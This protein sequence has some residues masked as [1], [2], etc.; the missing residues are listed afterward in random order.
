MSLVV[1]GPCPTSR[2][3]HTLE[4]T[5]SSLGT[6][7]TRWCSTFRIITHRPAIGSPGRLWG[8]AWRVH[9][10]RV[11]LRETNE[12]STQMVACVRKRPPDFPQTLAQRCRERRRT[13]R[14]R[15]HAG[16]QQKIHAGSRPNSSRRT[17]NVR[18]SA[19]PLRSS[20][21]TDSKCYLERRASS[22]SFGGIRCG[23]VR[24]QRSGSIEPD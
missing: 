8:H 23:A 16:S 24:R 18:S 14:K 13:G 19:A 6:V 4:A 7:D 9:L 15:K 21:S 12:A 2:R 11:G 5:H 22:E 20:A 3:N 17:P 10:R 1:R